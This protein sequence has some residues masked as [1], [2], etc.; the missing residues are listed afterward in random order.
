[1]PITMP[2]SV[3]A[4]ISKTSGMVDFSSIREWYL[5]AV[6]GLIIPLN[7]VFPS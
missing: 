2:S 4:D 5:G 3:C 1:M 7:I 6:K